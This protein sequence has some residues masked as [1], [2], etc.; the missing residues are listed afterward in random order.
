M[1][2]PR[3]KLLSHLR[4]F[5][6]G[7]TDAMSQKAGTALPSCSQ[8]LLSALDPSDTDKEEN[9]KW[10]TGGMFA[11]ASDTVGLRPSFRDPTDA[12]VLLFRL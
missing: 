10:S 5:M 12:Q 4:F 3:A 7:F 9:I 2:G 11:A 1:S 8:T 6:S